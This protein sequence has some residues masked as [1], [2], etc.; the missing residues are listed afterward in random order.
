[1]SRDVREERREVP[2]LRDSLSEQDLDSV[3][4][5]SP[6]AGLRRTIPNV[7]KCARPGRPGGEER[8]REAGGGRSQGEGSAWAAIVSSMLA[9]PPSICY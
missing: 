4:G 3:G 9:S 6:R 7:E 2:C 5:A 8:S 1:M